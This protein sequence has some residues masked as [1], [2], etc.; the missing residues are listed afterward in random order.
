MIAKQRWQV[1]TIEVLNLVFEERARQV[2]K[3]GH[4]DGL[5]N[6]TGP[7][8]EWLWPLSDATA[9]QAQLVLRQ[10]MEDHRLTSD[11]G[12]PT[13]AMMLL[14]ELAEAFECDDTERLV[15]ELI[16]VAAVAVQWIEKVSHLADKPAER[17]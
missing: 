13:W 5:K 2:E 1:K 9:Y 16:Q 7:N 4:N 12:K 11:T 8:V 10:A 15:E 6:G 14:E 17:L 3:H